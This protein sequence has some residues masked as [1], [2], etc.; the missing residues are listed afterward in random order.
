LDNAEELFSDL[1]AELNK[2]ELSNAENFDK[3]VLTYSSA[4]LA[5]SLAF[6]K[7][8]LPITKAACG[9][10][11]YSSWGLFTLSIIITIISY[12]TSQLGIKRQL[13]KAKRY[14]L[15]KEEKAFYERNIFEP[16]TEWLNYASGLIF[17]MAVVATTLFVSINLER[18]TKMAEQKNIVVFK[19][20]PQ[21][22][23]YKAAPIP[24]M[25]QIA[26]PEQ[27]APQQPTTQQPA[28]TPDSPKGGDK[29]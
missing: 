19:N 24:T 25:Q 15:D 29:Q 14:Y 8:F 7:D 3:S 4:G 13:A 21:G 22:E 17:V 16:L 1:K 6:L 9:W 28:S 27:P 23:L 10:L 20:E 12:I 11:L 26:R 5:F 18:A 2:R